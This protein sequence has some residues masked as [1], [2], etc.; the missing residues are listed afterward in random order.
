MINV[1]QIDLTKEGKKALEDELEFR[2][3]TERDRIKEAIKVAREQGDLSENADYTSAREEQSKNEARI[4]EIE[5]MLKHAHIVEITTVTVKY[6]K[7]NQVK[8]YQI[9]GSE[10]DPFQGKI[11]NESPLAKAVLNHKV[12]DRVFMTTEAGKDME[13]EILDIKK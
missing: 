6:I 4:S 12:G 10:T 3:V 11:S 9:C 1:K 2:T 7:K 8:T 5:D 13:L